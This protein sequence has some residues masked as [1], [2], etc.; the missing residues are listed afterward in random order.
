MCFDK[1]ET[2]GLT[3]SDSIIVCKWNEILFDSHS[4]PIHIHIHLSYP[5][6][7]Q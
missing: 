3:E 2:N 4:H 6:S 5:F 7:I 1:T